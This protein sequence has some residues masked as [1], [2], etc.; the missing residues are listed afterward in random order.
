MHLKG[1]G[2]ATGLNIHVA[3][4]LTYGCTRY[5]SFRLASDNSDGS[6]FGDEVNFLHFLILLF[7]YEAP[8]QIPVSFK[9]L[10]EH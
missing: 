8:N 9:Y 10:L 4:A 7:E 6:L 1:S 3:C 2:I 5:I